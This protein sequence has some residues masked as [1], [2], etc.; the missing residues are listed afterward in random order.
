M[1][2]PVDAV[3]GRPGDVRVLRLLVVP[4]EQDVGQAAVAEG[5]EVEYSLPPA[6]AVVRL[7][8]A[9]H[10]VAAQAFDGE[11]GV[12][13]PP[14][15]AAGIQQDD[16][17]A[18]PLRLPGVLFLDA[19]DAGLM[20]VHDLTFHVGGRADHV[21]VEEEM[22]ILRKGYDAEIVH[23]RTGGRSCDLASHPA[24]QARA[25]RKTA[26]LPVQTGIA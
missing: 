8:I 26:T 11:G 21:I 17:I 10:R 23:R 18:D 9:E 13:H 16:G 19:G 12:V 5:I 24:T 4:A 2:D 7:G 14:R 22:R 1:R 25:R 3:V 6:N 20:R 15:R